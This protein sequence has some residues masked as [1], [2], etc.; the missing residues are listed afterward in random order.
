[1]PKLIEMIGRRIGK[2]VVIAPVDRTARIGGP[3]QC[4]SWLCQCDCGNIKVINGQHLR[5]PILP[6]RSCGCLRSKL[7]RHEGQ[8]FGKLVVLEFA[9]YGKGNKYPR[10]RCRCDCGAV[11]EVMGPN[12]RNGNTTSCGCSHN[13]DLDGEG[14]RRDIL[15]S[16]KSGA[17][18]RNRT[19][20]ISDDEATF[21]F[22]SDCHYCGMAPSNR[23]HSQGRVP[24]Y[25]NGI[26]RID[27]K[28]G[29]ES[30]N[31][32]PCCRR[33]NFAKGTSNYADFINWA[34]RIGR[35]QLRRRKS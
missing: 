19:W 22:E 12:L 3:P 4:A 16:Y 21:L 14:N 31:V 25:Y 28:I 29:Y 23:A 33:C 15:R 30:G 9:G 2:L 11:I 17:K 6:T 26:D 8:R 13:L 24:Y 10:W 7:I 5:R 34:K 1:M 18:D 35:H 27:N 32:I 20:N